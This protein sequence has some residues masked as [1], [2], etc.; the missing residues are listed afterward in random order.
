MVEELHVVSRWR[1]GRSTLFG[2]LP[3]CLHTHTQTKN[4]DVEVERR[5]R[6]Q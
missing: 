5:F 4:D 1:G 3:F 6:P 2:V